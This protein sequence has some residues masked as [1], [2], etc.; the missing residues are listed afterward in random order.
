MKK[1]WLIYSYPYLDSEK[2]KDISNGQ[3]YLRAVVLSRNLVMREIS[4]WFDYLIYYE[5]E[6]YGSEYDIIE[7][8]CRAILAEDWFTRHSIPE[9]I[10][11]GYAAYGVRVE[12]HGG[13]DK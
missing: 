4:K 6:Q 8:S 5:A 11:E 13:V 1:I 7:E 2:E 3:P 12:C 10:G 9:N